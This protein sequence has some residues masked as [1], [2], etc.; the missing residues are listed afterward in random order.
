MRRRGEITLTQEELYCY[1]N[2]EDLFLFDDISRKQPN[3]PITLKQLL[4]QLTRKGLL[5]IDEDE[6]TPQESVVVYDTLRYP[7]GL[8]KPHDTIH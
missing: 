8:K 3:N 7:P 4:N 1:Q 6:S 2:P 5:P